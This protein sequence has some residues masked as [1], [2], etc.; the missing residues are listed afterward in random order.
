MILKFRTKRDVNGNTYYLEI[1]TNAKTYC[2]NPKGF[3]HNE[4]FIEVKK[5]DMRK[6]K[7]QLAKFEYKYI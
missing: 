6:L 4:D 1:D 2:E 3:I 7:S 5:T